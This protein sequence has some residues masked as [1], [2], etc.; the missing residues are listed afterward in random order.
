MRPRF[1]EYEGARVA[2]PTYLA[3]CVFICGALVWGFYEL[4]QPT[5]YSNPGLAAYKAPPGIGITSLPASISGHERALQ[6]VP[7]ES[8]LK[9]TADETTGRAT[10]SPEPEPAVA[11]VPGT[12]IKSARKQGN[13][14][15][16]ARESRGVR[17][18]QHSAPIQSH[19]FAGF[20]A[21][22]PGYA[23]LH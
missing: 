19:L 16:A 21:A 15:R 20:G 2:I 1:Q 7:N 5:R 10:Q 13:I 14:R 8:D 23:A 9:H 18:V 17:H 3:V 22:Y 11:S 12:Q 4:M 6:P